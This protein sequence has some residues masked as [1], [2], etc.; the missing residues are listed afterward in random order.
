MG[1]ELAKIAQKNAGDV[2]PR[3][4]VRAAK[5]IKSPLHSAFE[6]NNTKAGALYR[7]TQARAVI[8]SVEVVI[9]QQPGT[10][11]CTAVAY[12]SVGESVKGGSR[13]VTSAQAFATAGLRACVLDQ[14]MAQLR[15]WRKRYAVLTELSKLFEI[16]DTLD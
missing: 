10:K 2:T 7:E 8:R 15:G 1:N 13:Y 3:A 11:A 16:I 9:V 4:V 6:W 5:P 12:V 14:A